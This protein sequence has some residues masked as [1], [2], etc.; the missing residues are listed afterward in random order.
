MAYFQENI[1]KLTLIQVP[2]VPVWKLKVPFTSS[3]RL[4]MLVRPNPS[5]TVAA[6]NPLPLSDMV[7]CKFVL[8]TSIEIFTWVAWAYLRALFTAS[9]V[10]RTRCRASKGSN[11]GLFANL[12]V[13]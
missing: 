12:A 13:Q 6:S 2:E 3:V 10:M 7:S 11:T 9:W 8:S 1:G 4:R 5:L